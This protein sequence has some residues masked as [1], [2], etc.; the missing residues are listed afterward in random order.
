[1]QA[2]AQYVLRNEKQGLSVEKGKDYD[3]LPISL[4]LEKLRT[5]K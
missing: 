1:M 4:V 3:G 5:G 2:F